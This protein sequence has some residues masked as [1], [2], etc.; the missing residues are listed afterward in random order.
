M[1]MPRLTMLRYAC[2]G[3]A[4]QWRARTSCLLHARRKWPPFLGRTGVRRVSVLRWLDGAAALG[5]T[6]RIRQSPVVGTA[7]KSVGGAIEI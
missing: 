3:Q 4:D 7:A 2:N 6:K 1:V 5:V